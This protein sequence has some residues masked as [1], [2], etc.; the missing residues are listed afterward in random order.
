[1]AAGVAE[2]R[3]G[4]DHRVIKEQLPRVHRR[5]VQIGVS[6]VSTGKTGMT[7]RS[8]FTILQKEEHVEHL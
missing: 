1:V 4:F 5:G 2:A 6:T 3:A 7:P 8:A